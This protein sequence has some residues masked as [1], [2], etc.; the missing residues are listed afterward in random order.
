MEEIDFK[1]NEEGEHPEWK[2]SEVNVDTIIGFNSREFT[3]WKAFNL[4]EDC[5]VLIYSQGVEFSYFY[6]VKFIYN[7]TERSFQKPKKISL[8][9]KLFVLNY[10]IRQRN[11]VISLGDDLV[12]FDEVNKE[13][14][15]INKI[16]FVNF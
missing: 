12:F 4:H 11:N 2:V 6:M 10:C 9:H 13:P 16:D 15:R 1:Q 7:N 8:N 3:Y 14:V 5:I